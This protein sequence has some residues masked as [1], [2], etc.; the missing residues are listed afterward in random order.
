MRRQRRGGSEN[1]ER[2]SA[3]N[4]STVKRLLLAAFLLAALALPAGA[5]AGGSPARPRV[6]AI[7]FTA[8]VNPVT[9]DWLNHELGQR[10]SQGYSA[11]VIV[12]DTP[13]GL[14]ES[15]RKIVARELVAEDP[16][17]RLRRAA[18]RAR[19]LGRRLDLAGRRRARDGA[20]DEHRL[21]DAD[22]RHAARTSAATCGARS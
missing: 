13:G 4:L 22:Q 3:Y 20:A 14:E 9:Q 19:R 18:R 17:D 10:E 15:M 21:V 7:H 6:L 5:A 16:G 11:A 1:G 12:L 2:P 8:D